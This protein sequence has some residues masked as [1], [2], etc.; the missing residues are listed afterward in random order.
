V[1][2]VDLNLALQNRVALVAG[3]SRGIGKS[4]AESLLAEGCLVAITGRD[5]SSLEACAA[6]LQGRYGNSTVLP[7][8]GDLTDPS[9]ITAAIKKI[10]ENWGALNFAIANVGTGR[11]QPGWDVDESEWQ[12]LFEV[13]L[14]G[15]VRLARAVVP[16][17]TAAGGGVILFVSSI[18][19]IETT[20]APLPYSASKAALINYSKNLSRLLAQN[21]IRVN[22]IAP[23]NVRFPG[24]SWDKHVES[25]RDEVMHYIETEVPLKRF[26]HPGEIGDLA[27]FLCSDKAAF[28]TGACFVA[29]GG[30]TRSV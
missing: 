8:L 17:M 3:S 12:R 15:S 13:N 23:G 14:N 18:T 25:R 21:A 1:E 26:G 19:G 11:G 4:I 20:P 7:F 16:S 6:E 24:G 27:A 5:P 28:I 10:H 9:V 30:Q 29:D 22:C 2:H